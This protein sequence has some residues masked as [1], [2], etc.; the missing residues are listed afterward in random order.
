MKSLLLVQFC[1]VTEKIPRSISR[2][3]WNFFCDIPGFVFV[4]STIYRGTPNII[5]PN[6][7]SVVGGS[8]LQICLPKI[9]T[10]LTY[11][12]HATFTAYLIVIWSCH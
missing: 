6:E 4:Y 5:L 8:T 12:V 1:Q 11:F 10:Y 9:Y 3:I 7:S 2:N